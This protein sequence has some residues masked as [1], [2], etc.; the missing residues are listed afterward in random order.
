[1]ILV[2]FLLFL[3]FFLNLFLF[4]CDPYDVFYD[5]IC[6]PYD[7]SVIHMMYMMCLGAQEVVSNL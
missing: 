3:F 7:V 6:D 1:V 2:L 5:V 4:F